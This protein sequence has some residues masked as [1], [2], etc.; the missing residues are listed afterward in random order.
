MV[1]LLLSIGKKPHKTNFGW[2]G[3]FI[4][5]LFFAVLRVD[6]QKYQGHGSKCQVQYST[7][8]VVCAG[9]HGAHL[10]FLAH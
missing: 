9:R 1:S 7:G 5:E 4:E 6:I 10:G 8:A 3:D 2:L